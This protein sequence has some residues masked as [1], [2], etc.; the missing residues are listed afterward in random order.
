MRCGHPFVASAGLRPDEHPV[1]LR[2]CDLDGPLDRSSYGQIVQPID[3][4][5][6]FALGGSRYWVHLAGG[7]DRAVSSEFGA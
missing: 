3:P 7:G 5:R 6:Y 1:D 4:A 2:V